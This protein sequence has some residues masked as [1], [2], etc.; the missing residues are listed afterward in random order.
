MKLL[1]F[2]GSGNSLYVAKRIG[3]ERLSIPQLIKD[4][5][6]EIEDDAV[7][8]IAPTY[9]GEVPAMVKDYLKKAA[10]KTDY[11][12]LIAT[13]GNGAANVLEEANKL[14][15]ARKLDYAKTLL[16]VDNF[17]M[18]FDM[19][20]EK[21]KIPEKNIEGQLEQIISDIDGRVR[22]E[23]KGKTPDRVL[24]GV[25]KALTPIIMNRKFAA[26]RYTVNDNCISCGICT[27]VCPAGNVVLSGN[28]P[29]FGENCAL[30]FACLHNCPKNAI[31]FKS[32]KS[33]ARFVNDGI[34]LKE[35]IEANN[36]KD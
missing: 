26:K 18:T 21:A 27:K 30:C 2:T 14:L 17:I 32:E 5:I 12:F 22:T 20:E 36:Q 19:D 34:T 4:N 1:Y 3:G 33:T 28:K 10:F 16:M 31:H 7:G 8:I 25:E 9:M 23:I 29:S 11:L 13:Y 24:A 35:I 15:K 6:Y